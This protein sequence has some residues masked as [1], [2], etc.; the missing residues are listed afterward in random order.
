MTQEEIEYL[1]KVP[2]SSA[3]GRLMYTMVCTRPNIAHAVGFVRR[4]MNNIGK[5]NWREV[6]WILRYLIGTTSH[7]LCFGG[8]NTVLQVYV[9]ADMAGDKDSRS[10]TGYVFAV[11]GTTVSWISKL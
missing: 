5:H 6:Q 3:I 1:S 4:Y 10:T 8:S 2:Y 11:G 9:D 7:A